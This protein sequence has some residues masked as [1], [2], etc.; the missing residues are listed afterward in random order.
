MATLNYLKSYSPFGVYF[1]RCQPSLRASRL[2]IKREK[3]SAAHRSIVGPESDL[4]VEPKAALKPTSVQPTLGRSISTTRPKESIELRPQPAPAFQNPPPSPFTSEL[5]SRIPTEIDGEVLDSSFIGM[6]G[7]MIFHE[8]MLRHNVKHVFGYPGGAILPV[9]DAIYNSKHFNF[10]L[11]RH[12]Q[13][14]GHMAEG[15]ARVSGKPGVVLV[16]SG[17]G[18]T[19]TITP[20]QDAYSDG[21]PMVVFT[22]QVATS[23]IGSDAFQ[24]AD[25]IGISRSC[26]KWNVMVKDVT[27][28]PRRINEAFKIATSGRPGPVLVDLPKDM[29]AGI[30]RTPIPLKYTQPDLVERALPSNPLRARSRT[31]QP[32][33]AGFLPATHN[34]RQASEMIL[35][36]KRP[37]VYAG[38]GILSSPEGPKL[39]KRLSDE[40]NIPV[41]TTLMGM[42]AFDEEDPKSLHMLGMHGSAYANLAMQDADVI[43]ALGARFDDRV[44]GKVDTFAPHARAAALQGRGGIIHFEV[45]PKNINK[46]IEATCAIE[47]DVVENLG[48]LLDIM[49]TRT[50]GPPS[51]ADWLGTIRTWKAK[52]PFIYEP[53][54]PGQLMK[55]QEVIEALDQWARAKPGRKDN[56]IISTGVGQHQMWAAQHYRWTSPRSI[57]TSGG[58]GTMGYGLPAAIGAKVAEPNKYVVDIDGDAS[59]SMTA[60][61]LATAHEFNIGVKVIVLDNEFQGM[62]LQWQDLFYESRYSSTRMTNPNFFALAKSMHCHAIYCDK[63][64]DLPAKMAEFMEYDNSR[65]VLFHVKV[66][67][68]EHCF[69]M[70]PAGKA[71]HQ[72]I[73][74]P[75]LR[76]SS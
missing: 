20:L 31:H 10:I 30:L 61:E 16:T 18:A 62:V 11:P 29:T 47:G 63:K 24:E 48:H 73:L 52:Y 32:T 51:R 44:T 34:L 41:T 53:S 65:P 64:E 35:A 54:L 71:L 58:L 49:P 57:V 56:L 74:H 25:V 8:M 68:R 12:E 37:L 17:P 7:G 42:G 59:L 19:N 60:M 28:L 50:D 46:V 5:P 40:W 33:S 15:Y 21:T 9:F 67:D 69:P 1:R 4:A 66:T 38:Q 75:L 22:G 43:I 3:S 13:G 39:L 55:P 36:A 45:Q 76:S 70:V 2:S 14:A 6:S 26:T 72:Q 23:A 27:D